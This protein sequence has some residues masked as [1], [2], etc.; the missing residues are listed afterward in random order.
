[1]TLFSQS[2]ASWPC[3]NSVR[4]RRSTTRERDADD[5][6]HGQHGQRRAASRSQGA[7]TLA[8]MIRNTDEMSDATACDTNILTASTSEVRCVS[9]AA[10][11]DLLDVGVILGRDLRDEPRAQIARDPLRRIGLHDALQVGEDEDAD[12]R[13]QQLGRNDGDHERVPAVTVDGICHEPRNQQVEGVAGHGQH[14]EQAD[15]SSIRNE[16]RPE[17]GML[18][19]RDCDGG[20]GFR[21]EAGI[22][23]FPVARVRHRYI[24]G[25]VLRPARLCGPANWTDQSCCC[26][27]ATRGAFTPGPE[28]IDRARNVAI[29]CDILPGLILRLVIPPG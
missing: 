3:L 26:T 2:M 16:Q 14:H 19:R 22:A 27:G 21:H 23:G 10:G 28:Q 15:D 20:C 12:G 9:S 7:A 18:W 17:A 1:M 11:V 24:I 29:G 4:T 13:Q 25:G 8:P 6:Q 5:R